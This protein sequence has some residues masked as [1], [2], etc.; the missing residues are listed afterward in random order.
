MAENFP[1]WI[2]GINSYIF[3][4]F[5]KM[6]VVVVDFKYDKSREIH[7]KIYYNRIVENLRKMKKS[8]KLD[9]NYKILYAPRDRDDIFQV[10]EKITI[11]PKFYIQW[12]CPLELEWEIVILRRRKTGRFMP[13]PRPTLKELLKAPSIAGIHGRR[14]APPLGGRLKTDLIQRWVNTVRAPFSQRI[15]AKWNPVIRC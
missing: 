1:N 4:G 11:N 13:P 15:G 9:R 3:F 2:W 8:P 14:A 10:L 7:A 5:L 12:H 6:G